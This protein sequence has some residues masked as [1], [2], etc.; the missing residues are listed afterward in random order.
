MGSTFK[1]MT[2]SSG[3][4]WAVLGL[5]VI[6]SGKG[7]GFIFLILGLI[8]IERTTGLGEEWARNNPLKA[9]YVHFT[10]T[11]ITVLTTIMAIIML[12]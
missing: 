4:L 8:Y 1:W 3:V 7:S 9:L 12:I 11:I 6:F 5:M 2:R 10:I